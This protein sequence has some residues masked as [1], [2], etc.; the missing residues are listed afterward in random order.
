MNSEMPK[1]LVIIGGGGH[2]SIL[3]DILRSQHREIVAVISPDDISVRTVFRGIPQLKRDEEILNFDRDSVNLV[4]GIGMLPNSGLRQ[5]VNEYFLSL[6]YQFE[7]VIADSAQV[8]PFAIVQTG[9]QVL[10]GAII[11]AG[12]NIGSHSIVNTGVI[13]EHDCRIGSY[14][15]IAPR[16]TLCGQVLVE[17]RVFV[18]AG[19]V[20]IQNLTIAEGCIVGAGVTL[21]VSLFDAQ[22]CYC[23]KPATKSIKTKVDS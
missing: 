18:G 6:G 11:Q 22:I 17:P 3:T 2:A 15:H 9:A 1:P 21:A 12:A 16:A 19:A 8:S 14:C 4:N 23:T 10:H 13:I 20:I 7:S 5:K